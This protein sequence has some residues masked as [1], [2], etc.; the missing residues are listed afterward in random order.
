MMLSGDDGTL[1]RRYV[2]FLNILIIFNARK[3]VWVNNG[4]RKFVLALILQINMN[5][6]LFFACHLF[7]G[8]LVALCCCS[9]QEMWELEGYGLR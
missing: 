7:F 9:K 3:L 2:A 4:C 1:H 6:F 8:C 5:V